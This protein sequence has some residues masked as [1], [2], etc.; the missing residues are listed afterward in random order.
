MKT[1]I[2]SRNYNIS[3]R[4]GEFEGEVC[5]EARVKELPDIIEY[6]D[7]LKKPTRSPLIPLKLQW[8][9]LLKKGELF[10]SQLSPPMIRTCAYYNQVERLC[11]QLLTVAQSWY[12]GDINIQKA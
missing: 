12:S 6:A 5:F 8:K 10:L 1:M 9:F 11:S 3:I 4:R 2:D 7:L